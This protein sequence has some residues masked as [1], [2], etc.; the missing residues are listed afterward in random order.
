MA[1]VVSPRALT[2]SAAFHQ[3]FTLGVSARRT[4]PTICVHICRVSR[5]ACQAPG[6]SA[7]QQAGASET[8]VWADSASIMGR[9]QKLQYS[10]GCGPVYRRGV[11][12]AATRSRAPLFAARRSL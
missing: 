4:L 3:W 7:G 6:G 12:R 9:L 1:P 11:G 10:V 8:A 5:V 2:C